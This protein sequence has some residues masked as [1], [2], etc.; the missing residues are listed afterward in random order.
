MSLALS[1]TLQAQAVR[2]PVADWMV[3]ALVLA[4]AVLVLLILSRRQDHPHRNG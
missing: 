2:A 4:A 1:A 3:W